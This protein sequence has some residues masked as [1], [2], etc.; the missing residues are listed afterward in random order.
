MEGRYNFSM[1]KTGKFKKSPTTNKHRVPFPKLVIEI[2]K[3]SDII[4]EVLD[5]RFINETR[6]L[7][8]ENIVKDKSKKL[9]YVLNKSDL[10]RVSDLKKDFD[11][12]EIEPYVLFSC[13]SKIGRKRL[14]D[15]I[16]FEVKKLK[17][18]EKQARIGVIGYP[19]TGKSSLINVL[20]MRHG[21]GTSSQPGY[22]KVIQKIRFN[23]DIVILDTPGVFPEKENPETRA[24][25]LKKHAEIGTS[26]FNEVRE[27]E[28]VVMEIM[29]KNP[30]ILES[31]YGIESDGDV[32]IFLSALGEK[33][34]FLKK[35]GRVDAVRTARFV[36]KDWQTGKIR[37]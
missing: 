33:K 24:S 21:A 37:A 9:I 12:K 13:V 34:K 18:G 11:L 16:K 4:L 10:I 2:I 29:K 5:A 20:A 8:M 15:R 26:T 22:T 7:E 1:K 36:L 23:K 17:L 32:E 14:R 3:T 27:P 31:F 25:A 28:L 30:R 6:N 19:N 35:G